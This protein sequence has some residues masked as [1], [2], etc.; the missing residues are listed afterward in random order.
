MS[1]FFEL[2]FACWTAVAL[3]LGASVP[4]AAAAIVTLNETTFD[5][6]PAYSGNFP[7]PAEPMTDGR[8]PGYS[9]G[10]AWNADTVNGWT[11]YIEGG[12]SGSP[13]VIDIGAGTIG[14]AVTTMRES[15]LAVGNPMATKTNAGHANADVCNLEYGS[16]GVVSA[17]IQTFDAVDLGGGAYGEVTIDINMGRQDRSGKGLAWVMGATTD[18]AN[19][20]FVIP[21]VNPSPDTTYTTSFVPTSP[22]FQIGFFSGVGADTNA[23]IDWIRVTSEAADGSIIP[24]PAACIIWAVGLLGLAWSRRR[25][26]PAA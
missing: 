20:D 7:N 11:W 22:Q 15:G 2:R 12:T 8:A 14:A 1:R 23:S 25:R 26:R 13:G 19:F 17:I 10:S 3:F 24:E 21:N 9:G 4:W 18:F 5:G 16:N 6:V